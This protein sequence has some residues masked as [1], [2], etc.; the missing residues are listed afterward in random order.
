MGAKWR[1]A[2]VRRKVCL[3]S[4]SAKWLRGRRSF[5]NMRQYAAQQPAESIKTFNASASAAK[6][7]GPKIAD[8][9]LGRPLN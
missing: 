8:A 7:R 4:I 3:V 9:A 6:A 1:P 2:L 5:P